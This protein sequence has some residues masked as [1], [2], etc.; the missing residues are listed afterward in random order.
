MINEKFSQ[1]FKS[2]N[3][4]LPFTGENIK[5]IE[6]CNFIIEKLIQ[7]NYE[8]IHRNNSDFTLLKTKYY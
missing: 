4:D 7:N 5:D 2:L 3:L 6:R 1:I 8:L